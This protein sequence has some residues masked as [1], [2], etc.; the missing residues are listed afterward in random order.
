MPCSIIDKDLVFSWKRSRNLEFAFFVAF[1]GED[2]FASL[3]FNRY[4]GTGS[5]TVIVEKNFD[6]NLIVF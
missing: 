5:R 6:I 4:K 3:I 2:F 1:F